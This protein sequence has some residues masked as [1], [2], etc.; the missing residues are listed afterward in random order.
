MPK[1]GLEKEAD[2]SKSDYN[3]TRLGTGPFII[4]EFKAGDSITVER[5]ANYRKKGQPY[6]DKII[7]RS[8]PSREVAVA[9]L[10]AGEVQGMWNL[11]EAQTPDLERDSNLK[12]VIV[13]TARVERIE[14]NTA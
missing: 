6:L 13:P 8:V 4:S 9:Q 11:L 12:V 10:K 1:H 5:N 14:I 2:I 7:F 3:R